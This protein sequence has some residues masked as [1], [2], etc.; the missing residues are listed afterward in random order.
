MQYDILR[1][2]LHYILQYFIFQKDLKEK[3][4]ILRSLQKK[5]KIFYMT[6]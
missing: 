6:T 2:K 4:I 5:I 1:K 3:H